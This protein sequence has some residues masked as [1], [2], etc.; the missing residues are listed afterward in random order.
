MWGWVVII[1]VFAA[2]AYWPR[3]VDHVHAYRERRHHQIGEPNA[4]V[5]VRC[6]TCDG[7]REWHST[8][9]ED[10]IELRHFGRCPDCC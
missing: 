2:W 1:T 8:T 7:T 4:H 10:P 3:A 5:N 6:N 9:E